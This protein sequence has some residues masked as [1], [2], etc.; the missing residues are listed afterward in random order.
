[1]VITL[2]SAVGYLWYTVADLGFPRGRDTDPPGG[3]QHTTLPNFPKKLHKIERIWTR[4]GAPPL[5]PPLVYRSCL[6]DKSVADDT[7]F[8]QL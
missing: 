8:V 7:A 2:T 4:G 5:D 1:M 6:Y 3:R